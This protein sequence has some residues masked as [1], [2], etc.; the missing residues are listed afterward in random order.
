[1]AMDE[2]L[3]HGFAS[4]DI[5][6]PRDYKAAFARDHPLTDDLLTGTFFGGPH[7]VDALPLDT[8][9]CK[10]SGLRVSVWRSPS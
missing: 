9:I 3:H 10:I 5:Y 6:W 8:C 2:E 1:M 7:D 4:T